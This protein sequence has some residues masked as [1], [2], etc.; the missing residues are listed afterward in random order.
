MPE[1]DIIADILKNPRG[2]DPE[3]LEDFRSRMDPDYFTS[4]S[5]PQIRTHLHLAASLTAVTPA[6]VRIQPRGRD[7]FEITIVAY[8]YFAEFSVIC[9]L[10]TAFGL[11]ILSGD[12]WTYYQRAPDP[13]PSQPPHFKHFRGTPSKGPSPEKIIDCFVIRPQSGLSFDP[14]RQKAFHEEIKILVSLL[15][16]GQLEKVRE[17][18]NP[19]LTEQ[20]EKLKGKLTGLLYPV[21]VYFDNTQSPKWTIMD[22]RSKDAPAFLYA[23]SNALAMR[24]I[25]VHKVIIRS[26]PSG[27]HDRFFITDPWGRKIDDPKQLNLLKTTVAL[28]KQFTRYLPWA[29]DPGKAIRHFDQFL[30][31]ILEEQPKDTAASFFRH[32]EHL[33]VLARLLGTSD[34]LW[35]DFLRMQ[36]ENLFPILEDIREKTA[37]PGKP[38][39]QKNL[40]AT[41]SKAKSMQEKKI[42]LN[43]FKDREMFAIDMKHLLEPQNTLTAFSRAL[44]ALAEVV[45]DETYR[46][47]DQH[48][49]QKFGRPFLTDGKP[50]AFTIMGLGKFGGREMGYASDI[51]LMF[52]YEGSGQTDGRNSVENGEYFEELVRAMMDFLEARQEGIFHIDLRLRPYGKA[53]PS[54]NP[55]NQWMGYYDAFGEAEPFERQALIK[56]RGVAGDESLGQRV[57]AHRDR[58]V[59]SA[60]PWDRKNALHLRRRQMQELVPPEKINVKY[61]AGGI[62]DIEYSTQYLQI[63]HGSKHPELKSPSTIKALEQLQE[64]GLV[65]TENHRKL[66]DAYLFLRLLI[67]AL[68]IVRGNARD[69]ILPD[70]NSEEFK[71]LARRLGYREETWAKTA[72]KL[73]GDIR[74]HMGKVHRFF[75][76]QFK[77]PKNPSHKPARR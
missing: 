47:C 1:K 33:D 6:A 41:L 37:H 72:R 62:I 53:G 39:I 8:D 68:R 74:G 2:I 26:D 14:S 64:L 9:G 38:T 25:Y 12:I 40:S 52:V 75:T 57:E 76:A 34:F 36:F 15:A 11:D 51:E 42:A 21:E 46:I 16:D 23:F 55:L 49:A 48:I 56:L 30:D 69:L 31:K 4:Y 29:P 61:S 3:I 7:R 19:A 10:M 59:Y 65:S 45:L 50:C 32:R 35:E 54:S 13:K 70:R 18:L 66:R 44:G 20:L 73:A 71:F 22:V 17:R 58:F 5:A 28:I 77:E 63:Q 67:D 60:Q 24:N 27:V 43:G